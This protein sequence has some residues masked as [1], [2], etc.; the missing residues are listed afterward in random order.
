[1]LDAGTPGLHVYTFNKHRPALDLLDRVGL[2][3]R[4]AA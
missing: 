3:G 4:A 2:S 1:V